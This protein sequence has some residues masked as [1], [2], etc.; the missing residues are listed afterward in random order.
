MNDMT[1]EQRKAARTAMGSFPAVR[2]RMER[3]AGL[4]TLT[5]S[6]SSSLVGTPVTVIYGASAPRQIIK[7]LQQSC[8]DLMGQV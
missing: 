2:I 1:D 6:L 4:A 5:P 3:G 8:S 7:E